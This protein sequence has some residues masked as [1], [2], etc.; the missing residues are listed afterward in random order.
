MKT[1][2]KIIDG[3]LFAVSRNGRKFGLNTSKL[4]ELAIAFR[5]NHS[6]DLLKAT[7]LTLASHF[8]HRVGR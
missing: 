6:M 7:Q 5:K 1:S 4:L 2:L 3:K 8:A